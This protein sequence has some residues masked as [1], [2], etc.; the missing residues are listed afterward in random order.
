ML[1]EL[2]LRIH[3]HKH[4]EKN[5]IDKGAKFTHEASFVDTYFNQPPG[6]V[7]KIVEKDNEAFINI[8]QAVNGKFEVVKDES[9]KNVKEVKKELTSK[10]G[11][12]RILKGTRTFFTYKNF[13]II[14]NLI[15]DVGEFLILVGENPSTD[16][17]EKE[18]Q[19]ENPKYITVSFDEI[20]AQ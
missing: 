7:Y 12:K 11:I 9:I 3:H 1:K 13:T 18:L 19:I 2:K 20:K 15:D 17:I 6:R 8:F 10:Y 16:V 5:L 4:I 14:F